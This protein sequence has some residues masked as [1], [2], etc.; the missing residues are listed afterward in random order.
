MIAIWTTDKAGDIALGA[1]S[2]K[3][4]LNAIGYLQSGRM[5]RN[6]CNGFTNAEWV[7]LFQ[8][9]LLRRQRMAL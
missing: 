7:T 6:G 4:I 3:H 1:M 5:G 8:V 2:T 9:E